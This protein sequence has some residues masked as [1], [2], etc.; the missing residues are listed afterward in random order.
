[1]NQ[2]ILIREYRPEDQA[3]A[4][5][6]ILAGLEEHW[7]WLDL[8]KNPDLDDITA[9]YGQET[10]LTAW[11][12]GMLVGT[13]ALV[14]EAEGV[15]RIVRMSVAHQARRTGIGRAILDRLV[16]LARARGFQRLVLETTQT[17]GDATGFYRSY[18]FH[19]IENRDGDSHF[20]MDV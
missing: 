18:G 8:S 10:F 4:R 13:G 3:A 7:G 6:L 17:W 9:S 19:F 2:E 1:M 14:R 11:C 12:E 5:N 16:A 15:G 20:F